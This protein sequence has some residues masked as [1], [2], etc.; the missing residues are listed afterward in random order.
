[1]T[2][3]R[4][5]LGCVAVAALG[6]VIV[7]GCKNPQLSGGILHFDQKRYERA[8]ETLLTA[9]QQEPNNA[10]AYYWLGMSYAEMDSTQQ[11]R[12]ALDKSIE[13]A[14]TTPASGTTKGFPSPRRP[15]TR[16]PWTRRR[17]RRRTGGWP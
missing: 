17:R 12:A 14:A 3:K 15:R 10:E 2:M 8:R 5:V 4:A 11:A 13:L 7:A 6:A 1:M 9:I 16:R